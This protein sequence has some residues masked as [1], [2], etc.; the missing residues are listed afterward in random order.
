MLSTDERIERMTLLLKEALSPS[1][2]EIIDDGDMH[3]GHAGHEQGLGHFTIHIASEV[4]DGKAL[5]QC[6]RL[7]YD[8][9]DELIGPEIHALKINVQR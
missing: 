3:K 1:E 5:L 7:V 2:L 4:F 8:A 9:V 6:H